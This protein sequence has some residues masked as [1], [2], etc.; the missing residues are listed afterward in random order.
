ML[1]QPV[2]NPLAK[3]PNIHTHKVFAAV[4]L[5]LIGVILAVAG[6]WWYVNN[7][8]ETT[9]LETAD[10]STK[11]STSSAKKTAESVEKTVEDEIAE[12]K[13]FTNSSFKYSLKYPEGIN[14][15]SNSPMGGDTADVSGDVIFT[16]DPKVTT[17]T[18]GVEGTIGKDFYLLQIYLIDKNGN[19]Y[20][21]GKTLAEIAQGDYNKNKTSAQSITEL[22]QTT[23]GGKSAYSFQKTKAT[24]FDYLAG[25]WLLTQETIKIL[26][27][28]NNGSIYYLIYRPN[29]TIEEILT[30]FKFL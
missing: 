21:T 15:F 3:N 5:I 1:E 26:E 9:T 6:I 27:V 30:T 17:E 18:R 25:G 29:D 2:P 19:S 7:Q 16:N 28:E 11:V 10:T 13:T 14:P 8:S 22:T 23:V 20:Y 4:G 12:W 24:A